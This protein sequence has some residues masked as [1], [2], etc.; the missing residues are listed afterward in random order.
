MKDSL[1]TGGIGEGFQRGESYML[2]CISRFN[3]HSKSSIPARG[4][5]GV[6]M[7]LY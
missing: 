6:F 1:G 3:R 5:G 2:I 4:R 7:E